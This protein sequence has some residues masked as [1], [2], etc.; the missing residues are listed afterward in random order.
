MTVYQGK[1][2]KG[3]KIIVRYPTSKDLKPLL[4][5]INTLSKEKTFI[6]FQGERI[7][8][9]EEREYLETRLKKIKNKEA[10]MLL[11]FCKGRLIGNSGIEMKDKAESHVGRFGI[12][13]A[14]GY[15]GEGIG[16]LLM[17]LV[18][19]EAKKK[20]PQLKII[21]IDVFSNNK[22]ASGLYKKFGFKK[23]GRLPRG[24]KHQEKLVNLL[25]LYKSIR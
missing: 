18:L 17:E 13:V 22:I 25:S 8:L 11:A 21:T 24:I 12:T 16:K 9:K 14:K 19:K 2:S 3:N 6:L 4:N 20:I 7:S 10:V 1:T 23:F 5:Y 15:R